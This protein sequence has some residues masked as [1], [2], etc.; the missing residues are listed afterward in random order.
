MV[1][2]FY[3]HVDKLCFAIFHKDFGPLRKQDGK[4]GQQATLNDFHVGNCYWNLTTA[5]QRYVLS[6]NSN[7]CSCCLHVAVRSFEHGRV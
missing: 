3:I 6:V 1:L 5:I 2:G 4:V 7:C